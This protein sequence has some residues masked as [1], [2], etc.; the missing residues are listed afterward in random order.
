MSKILLS[1][2]D[3]LSGT[4]PWDEDDLPCAFRYSPGDNDEAKALFELNDQIFDLSN[5][6]EG[7]CYEAM[8]GGVF[9]IAAKNFPD[10]PAE[11][12]AYY[13][14]HEKNHAIFF[15]SPRSR[16]LTKVFP[17][18]PK[19]NFNFGSPGEEHLYLS[20][21][22]NEIIFVLAEC[23]DRA[24]RK[25]I[26]ATF[27]KLCQTGSKKG[28]S[29]HRLAQ[30]ILKARQ[31]LADLRG[32]KNYLEHAF[33]GRYQKS[34]QRIED[35][36]NE[37]LPVIKQAAQRNYKQVADFAR[38]HL[39]IAKP[40]PWDFYFTVSQMRKRLFADDLNNFRQYFRIDTTLK[41]MLRFFGQLC[42]V[43]FELLPA[44]PDN[45]R[46][47]S[48]LAADSSSGDK[49]GVISFDLFCHADKNNYCYMRS[50]NYSHASPDGKIDLPEALINCD[51]TPNASGEDKFFDFEEILTLF[52]ELGHALE[53]IFI[54]NG[55]EDLEIDITEFSSKFIENFA[56][57]YDVLRKISGH[58]KTGAPL[59]KKVFRGAVKYSKFLNSFDLIYRLTKALVDLKIN[60]GPG[61]NF[62]QLCAQTAAQT[63]AMPMMLF[64]PLV[65]RHIFSDG[66]CSRYAANYY[67]YLYSEILAYNVYAQC[68]AVQRPAQMQKLR[69]EI[70]KNWGQ[71]PF[72]SS[73]RKLRAGKRVSATLEEKFKIA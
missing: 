37:C 57:D 62:N 27:Q 67:T 2:S 41:K 61:V 24:T 35:F 72:A 32:C 46:C 44:A 12:I 28:L 20:L 15:G 10:A 6:F 53:D 16:D 63:G 64:N 66:E 51:F 49:L 13:Q 9:R 45:A 21:R 25:K 33:D 50:G 73:Y 56:Y 52:H 48:F 3:A 14:K 18:S 30:R 65:D 4:V 26:Y 69:Q 5:S 7:N 23:H 54:G 36:L 71:R 17:L 59:P 39:G 22:R 60:Q 40:E 42:G 70:S 1:S 34:P 43:N 29:N 11:M 68:P 58:F 55:K 8:A 19:A 31:S 47:V 38:I